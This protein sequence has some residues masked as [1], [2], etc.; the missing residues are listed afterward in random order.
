MCII[1]CIVGGTDHLCYIC[2]KLLTLPFT[3]QINVGIVSVANEKVWQV[4]RK[5]MILTNAT[6]TALSIAWTCKQLDLVH[7]S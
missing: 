5:Q 3:M 2:A 4:Q 7:I 6:E 1:V